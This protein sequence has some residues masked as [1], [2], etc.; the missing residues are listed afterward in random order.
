MNCRA[1]RWPH[2]EYRIRHESKTFYRL[3]AIPLTICVQF[4]VGTG[5]EYLPL[6]LVRAT[7]IVKIDRKDDVHSKQRLKDLPKPLRCGTDTP[8]FILSGSSEVLR[9]RAFHIHHLVGSTS[10]HNPTCTFHDN[11]TKQLQK[12]KYTR[13]VQASRREFCSGGFEIAG[14]TKQGQK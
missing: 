11:S 6:S 5:V 4:F 9:R 3:I 7:C 10:V 2:E 8:R 14:D 13:E 12:R 1:P